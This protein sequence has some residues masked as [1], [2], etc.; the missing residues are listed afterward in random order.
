MTTEKNHNGKHGQQ[1][2]NSFLQFFRKTN[3]NTKKSYVHSDKR[4][5]Q[6]IGKNTR[7]LEYKSKLNDH[8]CIQ[9]R[10]PVEKYKKINNNNYSK[11]NKKKQTNKRQMH[12]YVII[13]TR[14]VPKYIK[15]KI[16]FFCCYHRELFQVYT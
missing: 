12:T 7:N 16:L 14:L 1:M 5:K 4:S 2:W 15:K 11:I 10:E 9:F 6:T 13:Y 8:T 3:Y